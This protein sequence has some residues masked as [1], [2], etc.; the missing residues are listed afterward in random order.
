L[1]SSSAVSQAHSMSS[2][3]RF[4]LQKEKENSMP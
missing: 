3:N 2:A 4:F 1:S